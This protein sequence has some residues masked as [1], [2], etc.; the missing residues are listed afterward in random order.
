MVENKKQFA[1]RRHVKNYLINR[2]DQLRVTLI[3]L[4]YMSVVVLLTV[5]IILY[6]YFMD[7]F[8]SEDLNVQYR[9]SQAFLILL[10]PLLPALAIIFILVTLHQIFITHRIWGPLVHMK[11]IARMVGNG[12]FSRKLFIRKNDYLK[13]ECTQLNEMI[14]GLSARI[15]KIME[16]HDRL[17]S[18]VDDMS[19][20]IEKIDTKEEFQARLKEIRSRVE[21]LTEALSRFK[22][23]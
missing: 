13:N 16:H 1:N 20:S 21:L 14:D 7:I 22:L 3:T 19:E 17:A 6:P 4:I 18:T 10:N 23:G 9:A 15:S 8:F 11:N 5:G 12:D 2:H